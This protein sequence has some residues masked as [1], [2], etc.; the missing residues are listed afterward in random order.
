[1]ATLLGGSAISDEAFVAQQKLLK[2]ERCWNELTLAQQDQILVT[3]R[4]MLNK[5]RPKD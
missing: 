4:S 2:I 1:M 5:S 3:I